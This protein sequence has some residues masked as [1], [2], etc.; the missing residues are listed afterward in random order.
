MNELHVYGAAFGDELAARGERGV[1]TPEQRRRREQRERAERAYGRGR[2]DAP[3]AKVVD[4]GRF[5]AFLQRCVEAAERKAQ[6]EDERERLAAR[7]EGRP[8]RD[9]AERERLK[10][11]EEEARARRKGE[12]AS[13]GQSGSDS[14]A[15]A[16]AYA[17]T[18]D[19]EKDYYAALGVDD[20][21]TA[22]EVKRAYKRI[23]LKY[24]PDKLRRSG[25]PEAEARRRL[26]EAM[27]AYDV[28]SNDR[29]RESYDAARLR[30][31]KGVH[32][33]PEMEAR[34]HLARERARAAR[35]EREKNK[36]KTPPIKVEVW[37]SLGKLF[38]GGNKVVEYTRQRMDRQ[39]LPEPEDK[40]Y[41]LQIRRGMQD[42]ASIVAEGEG[43]QAPLSHPGDIEFV[44][45]QKPHPEF[46]V[47]GRKDL[48]CSVALP[49]GGAEVLH[50][51][52][53]TLLSGA[54]VFR[55]VSLLRT[56][57][58]GGGA[59]VH[60][61]ALEGMP[62]PDEP[63][64]AVP[65]DLRLRVEVPP[66]AGRLRLLTPPRGHVA[67]L[68]S[69]ASAPL[70][71]AAAVSGCL[72]GWLPPAADVA[73]APDADASSP[74]EA[75]GGG[76]PR[77][78]VCLCLGDG[79]DGPDGGPGASPTAAAAAAVL[80][81]AGVAVTRVQVPVAAALH[82]LPDDE[83]AAVAA[84]G[85]VLVDEP[86][87]LWRASAT[88]AAA[89]APAGPP[90]PNLC[91][92]DDAFAVHYRVVHRPAVA[93]RAAPGLGADLVTYLKAGTRVSVYGTEGAWGQLD[94]GRLPTRTTV[95]EAWVLLDGREAGF[96]PLLEPCDPWDEDEAEEAEAEARPRGE[97]L[98]D[99]AR[100]LRRAGLFALLWEKYVAGATVVGVG[101]ACALLGLGAGL[102]ASHPAPLVP[103]AVAVVDNSFDS[104]D[105]FFGYLKAAHLPY[106]SRTGASLKGLGLAG[107]EFLVLQA[108]RLR[109]KGAVD[110][111]AAAALRDLVQGYLQTYDLE[112]ATGDASDDFLLRCDSKRLVEEAAAAAK[113]REQLEKR[114]AVLDAIHCAEALSFVEVGAVRSNVDVF[115]N[116]RGKCLG[117]D[118]CDRYGVPF[119]VNIGSKHAFLCGNCGCP[120][121]AHALCTA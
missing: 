116:A 78:C 57:L 74:G 26:A 115:G 56:R 14:G 83:L 105:D 39:G 22:K 58:A 75:H 61:V 62:D 20:T 3:P 8:V 28:L 99:A 16:G 47:D 65:G 52:R 66:S 67:L 112:G 95:A 120:H 44:L 33:D 97:V 109:C 68:G 98:A 106:A 43:D 48:V 53:R 71:L 104:L 101:H 5:N 88:A 72:G 30:K 13:G 93:V 6:I 84:A 64:H 7:R 29:A 118:A 82:G 51:L 70:G 50:L 111:P 87:A 24:H 2:G 32:L 11:A 80:R 86:A 34:I 46:A 23:A 96:G 10:Q 69:A 21:A 17:A 108:D 19:V 31:L 91:D 35:E 55:P 79:P 4:R 60:T 107:P 45:K 9:R 103:A 38:R 63:F 42:G 110:G 102:E 18:F 12:R 25:E 76:D 15:G 49:P 73:A 92:P 94:P 77:A 54:E 89:A 59:F 1:E 40:T 90:A 85:S 117:C 36:P 81:Q 27:E 41:H 37:V 119:N 100:N 121:D 114:R 113:R